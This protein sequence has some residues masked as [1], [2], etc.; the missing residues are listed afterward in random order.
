LRKE[1][2]GTHSIFVMIFAS[3]KVL[4]VPSVS[5][6]QKKFSQTDRVLVR[7]AFKRQTSD[8]EHNCGIQLI[9]FKL[10]DWLIQSFLSI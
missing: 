1:V 2:S 10:S 3:Q 5:V 7:P 4:L 9:T 6:V 8:G